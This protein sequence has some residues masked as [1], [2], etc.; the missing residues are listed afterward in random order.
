M[1]FGWSIVSER[2]AARNLTGP[3]VFVVAG[4]LLANPSWGIVTVDVESSTV[5]LL[6]ELTL[7]LLLF[8]D[9]SKVPLAAARHDL[10]LTSRLLGIGLPLSI[11]AGAALAIVLFPDLPIALAGLIAAGLAPDRRRARAH[12]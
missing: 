3:L 9:A 5:H 11:V 4:L 7:G 2:L 12:P 1:L 6:A 10:P 8:A